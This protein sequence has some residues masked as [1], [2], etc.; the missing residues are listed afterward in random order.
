MM[1]NFNKNNNKNKII[2]INS[3]K[4]YTDLIK[5][6]KLFNIQIKDLI[7]IVFTKDH[8]NKLFI[9]EVNNFKVINVSCKTKTEI[10]NKKRDNKY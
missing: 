7:F 2:S 8:N 4:I 9:K 5:Y 3:N 6:I 1:N 10:D